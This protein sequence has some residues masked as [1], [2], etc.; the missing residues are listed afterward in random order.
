MI[1]PTTVGAGNFLGNNIAY[2]ARSTVG[3]D[4][5]L[6][7]K[8]MVPVDGPPRRGVGLLGSPAFEIP[9]ST[10]TDPELARYRS[11]PEFPARLARKN[12]SNLLTIGAFLLRQLVLL[13]GTVLALM[14]A[15]EFYAALGVVAYGLGGLAAG[16]FA[17]LFSIGVERLSTGGRRLHPQSCSIYQP[18][19]WR[20][21]RMWKLSVQTVMA[22]FNG[23]PF[24]S[25]LWRMLGVRVGRKV[26]DGGAGIPEKTLVT[27]GDHVTI[28]SG[29]VV[30]CH[31]LED[32]AFRSDHTTIGS[33]A[34]LGVNSFVHYGVRVGERV[35]LDAD[36]FLMKGES[37]A[38][39]ARWRGNPATEV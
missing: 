2:P 5:L 23:T 30:Q 6:A 3:D 19:F 39:D 14:G 25:V 20:H 32:A 37:P 22:P 9:R 21:E 18:Y 8:V 4:C 28:N 38:A 10:R 12:R 34:T 16:L 33:G 13:Y 35:V 27:I 26:Y 11:G 17:L 1:S 15:Q 24:K 36:A 7:T 31:S 29:A